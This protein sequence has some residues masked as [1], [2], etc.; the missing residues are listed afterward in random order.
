MLALAIKKPYNE[1]LNAILFS[2]VDYIEYPASPLSMDGRAL[3]ESQIHARL[4]TARR[5]PSDLT[6]GLLKMRTNNRAFS[7]NTGVQQNSFLFYRY[8]VEPF[9]R[10][11]KDFLLQEWFVE[12]PLASVFRLITRDIYSKLFL[13]EMKDTLSMDYWFEEKDVP[14]DPNFLHF[15][16]QHIGE[17]T[18]LAGRVKHPWVI[19]AADRVQLGDVL[20]GQFPIVIQAYNNLLE[21]NGKGLFSSL[22]SA[23]HSSRGGVIN[24]ASTARQPDPR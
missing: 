9:H 15:F 6:T 2:W 12:K 1:S 10:T 7:A 4:D 3:D 16:G 17:F 11:V 19:S 20:L 14:D 21:K 23:G 18:S 24:D 13:A 5:E 22:P 8:C